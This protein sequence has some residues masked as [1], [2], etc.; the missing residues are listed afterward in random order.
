M[1]KFSFRQYQPLGLRL[2]H[3]LNALAIFGLLGTVL[4]RKTF[5]SWRANA[6]LI[7]TKLQAAGTA[8]TPELA[9]DI[10]VSIRDPMWD[11][12]IYLGLGLSALLVGRILVGF[13]VI[14]KCPANQSLK[15]ALDLRKVEKKDLP[16]AL[17][18]TLVKT[19]Y[20]FFYL[21]TL[22]MVLSGLAMTFKNELGL[23]KDFIGPIKE[24]HELMMWF[25]VVFVIGHLVGVVMAENRGDQGLVSDMIHGG[26]K[27]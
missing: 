7:E 15:S 23:T 26:D 12:H 24:I 4:L 5:L 1:N 2:W 18:F 3:W 10:A 14:K 8:I 6:A 17:H 27:D 25:F 21:A 19:S 16:H 11:W 20:A 13:L 9:K 22:F